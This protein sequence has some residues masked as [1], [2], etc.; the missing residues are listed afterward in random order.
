MHKFY[1][2]NVALAFNFHI[3]IQI[4]F[5]SHTFLIEEVERIC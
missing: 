1:L 4:P 5:F 2:V 3:K